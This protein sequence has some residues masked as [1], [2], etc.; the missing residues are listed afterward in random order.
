[1]RR[2]GLSLCVVHYFVK[3]LSCRLEQDGSVLFVY[4]SNHMPTIPL[5]ISSQHRNQSTRAE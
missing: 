1:M 2:L 4:L 3:Y 5:S